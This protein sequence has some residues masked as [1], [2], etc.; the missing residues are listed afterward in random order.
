MPSQDRVNNRILWYILT[1][2]P[3]KIFQAADASSPPKKRGRPKKSIEKVADI[4]QCSVSSVRIYF[5]HYRRLYNFHGNNIHILFVILGNSTRVER[6]SRWHFERIQRR[7]S[8]KSSEKTLL[9][10]T[11]NE[12]RRAKWSR[13]HGTFSV[14]KYFRLFLF[15][16]SEIKIR[17]VSKIFCFFSIFRILRI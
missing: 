11:R 14:S 17:F 16:V 13:L 2:L 7:K 3:W 10:G 8:R 12:E 4:S 15:Q 9:F 5:L 1:F 6:V